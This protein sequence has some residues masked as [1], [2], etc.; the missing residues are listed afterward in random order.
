MAHIDEYF[1]RYKNAEQNYIKAIQVGG[2][3]L[4]YERLAQLYKDKLNQPD[5]ALKV[6]EKYQ[7]KNK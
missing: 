2:S 4:T 1:K 3:K 5:K 7:E 6:L